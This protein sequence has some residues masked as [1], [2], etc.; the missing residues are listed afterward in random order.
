MFCLKEGIVK[1]VLY[2]FVR[3]Y[4]WRNDWFG[5]GVGGEE[6]VLGVRFIFLFRVVG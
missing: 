1:K 3:C 4:G 5:M 6:G 2:K